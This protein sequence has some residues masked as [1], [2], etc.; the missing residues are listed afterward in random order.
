MKSLSVPDMHFAMSM[1]LRSSSFQENFDSLIT[2][3]S[4]DVRLLFLIFLSVLRTLRPWSSK[5][6]RPSSAAIS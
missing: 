4:V 1:R 2:R 3:S 6:E 5:Y